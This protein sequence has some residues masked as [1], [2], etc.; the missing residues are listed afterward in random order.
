MITWLFD[1]R[2]KHGYIP[3]LIK[4]LS[5]EPGSDAW[6]NLCINPPFS[7][8]F[9]FLKY[10]ILDKVPFRCSLVSGNYDSPAYYPVNLNFFDPEID[11]FSLMEPDSLQ[12]LKQGDFKFLFYYSEGDNV[13]HSGIDK[14]LNNLITKHEINP[15]NVL[16]VI[17]NAAIDGVGPY[18]FFPDDELYYRMLHLKTKGWIKDV[19][20]ETRPYKFTY[21]N[22]ADKVWRRILASVLYDLGCLQ[23]AQFSYTGYKYETSS[24]DD[25]SLDNWQLSRSNLLE[26]YAAFSLNIPYKCDDLTIDEHNNHK[27]IH[28]PH[29]TNSYWQLIAETHFDQ[30]TVFLTEK[31]FKCILNLQPF[32]IAGNSSSLKLLHHL[33]YKTFSHVI[34]EKYDTIIDPQ[35]RM[36]EVINCIY[37]LEQRNDE[38]QINIMKHV[39]ETLEHNQK[40]FLAPKVSRIQELLNRLEY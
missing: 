6:Y 23:D 20:L 26:A 12:Q 9:R 32:V 18:R 4:D 31:T 36:Q 15:D 7:Y 5:I 19:S 24:V 35:K 27:Y 28:T 14:H 29:F 38:D 22:R 16:F 3:N 11:Y 13:E 34:R 8:E 21:L 2:S 17:A 40:L 37:S 39:K 1:N 30:E 25:D 33:G 10:C